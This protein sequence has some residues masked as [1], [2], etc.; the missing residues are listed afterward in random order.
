M[1]KIERV[2]DATAEIWEDRNDVKE[3]GGN[4]LK[5]WFGSKNN[6]LPYLKI[7]DKEI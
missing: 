3:I 7:K 5:N 1:K 6:I 2:G 4:G